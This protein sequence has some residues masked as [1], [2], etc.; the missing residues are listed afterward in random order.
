MQASSGMLNT[1]SNAD[2]MKK[3]LKHNLSA[4]ISFPIM[5]SNADLMKKGLKP[6]RGIAWLASY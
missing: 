5:V 3:G 1:V 6:E 4:F 2:L